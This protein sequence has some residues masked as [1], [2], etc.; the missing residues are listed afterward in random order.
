MGRVWQ[1]S[2]IQQEVFLKAFGKGV[3][4]PEYVII[5]RKSYFALGGGKHSG[6]RDDVA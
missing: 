1:K 5:R 2:T 3:S 6:M 4:G